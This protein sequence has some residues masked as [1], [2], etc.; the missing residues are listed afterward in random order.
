MSYPQNPPEVQARIKAKL[1]KGPPRD[2]YEDEAALEAFR[3]G[4]Q[5]RQDK[6]R[7]QPVLKR[8]PMTAEEAEGSLMRM[9]SAHLKKTLLAK[10]LPKAVTPPTSP[11]KPA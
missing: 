6:D 4:V 1:A 5:L 11:H 7:Q 10:T 8:Q 9:M 2:Q 3:K